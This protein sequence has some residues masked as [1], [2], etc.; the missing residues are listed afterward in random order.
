MEEF[1]AKMR[2]SLEESY[3]ELVDNVRRESDEPAPETPDLLDCK[4]IDIDD[5]K[6]RSWVK[7]WGYGDENK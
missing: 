7:S 5:N 1:A 2:G 6:L 3:P 4:G